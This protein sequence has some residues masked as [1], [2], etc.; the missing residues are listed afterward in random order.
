MTKKEFQ[1]LHQFSDDDMTMLTEVL[2][3]FQ[4]TI[5]RISNVN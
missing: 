5:V 3:M 2:K 1:V 4:A